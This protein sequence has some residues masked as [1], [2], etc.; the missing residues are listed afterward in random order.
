MPDDSLA[1]GLAF[2]VGGGLFLAG[3]MFCLTL[4]DRSKPEEDS[5]AAMM[6]AAEQRSVDNCVK[7]GGVAI[8]S[9][10]DFT[11]KDCRGLPTTARV[12]R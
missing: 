8:F 11:L 9:S 7:R 3:I 5:R 12:S 6:R 1:W 4:G 2:V 10:W